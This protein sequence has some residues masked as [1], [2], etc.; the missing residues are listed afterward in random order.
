MPLQVTAKRLRDLVPVAL[1]LLCVPAFGQQPCCHTPPA[2]PASSRERAILFVDLGTLHHRVSTHRPQAQRFFDQGLTLVYAFNFPEAYRSFRRAAA[3]DPHLAMAYWGMAL[4]LG[5]NYNSPADPD[6]EKN[7]YPMAQKALALRRFATAQERAYIDALDRRFSDDPQADLKQLDRDYAGAMRRVA[8]AYPD[9]LD[10]ATLYAESLMEIHPW[11]LW[12]SRGN[13]A[14]GTTELVAV[15]ESVLR[16][17]SDHLGANHFYIHAVEASPHPEWALPSADRIVALAPGAG[18]IVHMPSHIY[19]RVGDYESAATCN[20]AAV[21]I[22]R[23]YFRRQ[24][25][26]G[27]YRLYLAH[28]L[29]FLADARGMEGRFQDALAAAREAVRAR[30]PSLTQT[31]AL[32]AQTTAPGLELVRFGRWADVLRLKEP[33]RSQPIAH[34]LWHY[35]VGVASAATGRAAEADRHCQAL[36]REASAVPVAAT[37]G[38]NTARDI[39]GLAHTVLSARIARARRAPDEEIALLQKAVDLQDALGYDETADWYYPVRESLGG[40]LLRARRYAEAE[41]VFRADLEKNPR[42]GRS[43]YG[44]M[45]SLSATGRASEAALVRARFALAWRH[46]DTALTVNAL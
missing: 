20:E 17:D 5:P 42:S 24:P 1:W 28:N 10:A 29:N 44:L 38:L 9:D 36:G 27:E 13:P 6:I 16:R 25:A 7:A 23:A 2:S 19:M 33:G 37:V 11:Q 12:D 8:L 45:T 46:A 26:R 21:A 31:P 40:A 39:L 15:L 41:R 30:N 32:D 3:L 22:D 14:E 43:L 35:A 18:H 34:A 4:A